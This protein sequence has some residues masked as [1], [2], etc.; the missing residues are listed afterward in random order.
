MNGIGLAVLTPPLHQKKLQAVFNRSMKNLIIFFIIL[1]NKN[2]SIIIS[3]QFSELYSLIQ[4]KLEGSSLSVYS[5][6]FFTI[7]P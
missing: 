4:K 5:V 2:S 3:L 1:L 7:M 6:R